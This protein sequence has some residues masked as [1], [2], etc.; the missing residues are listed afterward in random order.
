MM[1]DYITHV[2]FVWSTYML[3][4]IGMTMLYCL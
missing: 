2:L 4:T 3:F 1:T